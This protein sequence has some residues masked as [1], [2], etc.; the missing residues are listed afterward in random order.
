MM[1][2][3]RKELIIANNAN[4]SFSGLEQFIAVFEKALNR[5]KF[6]TVEILKVKVQEIVRIILNFLTSS[7]M[8]HD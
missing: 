3:A 6:K 4:E 7:I 2:N 5:F 8:I 1:S